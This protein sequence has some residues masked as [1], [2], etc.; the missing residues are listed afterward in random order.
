VKWY[1]LTR[2]TIVRIYKTI[3]IQLVGYKYVAMSYELD[4]VADMVEA[5]CLM[6]FWRQVQWQH[7]QWL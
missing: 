7:V 4:P 6:L 1:S 2:V 3:I 5:G